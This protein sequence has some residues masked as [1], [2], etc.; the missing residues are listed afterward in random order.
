MPHTDRY[1]NYISR[2]YLKIEHQNGISYY[3]LDERN[4]HWEFGEPYIPDNDDYYINDDYDTDHE[5]AEIGR[6]HV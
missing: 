2:R 4:H 6:A 5:D 3:E 1:D